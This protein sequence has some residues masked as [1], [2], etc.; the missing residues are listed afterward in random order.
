MTAE[1]MRVEAARLKKEVCICV[2]ACV[3]VCVCVRACVCIA[4]RCIVDKEV[5]YTSDPPQWLSFPPRHA[6]LSFGASHSRLIGLRSR[7][8][9]SNKSCNSWKTW[10]KHRS[11][12]LSTSMVQKHAL[13]ELSHFERYMQH[14]HALW[15]EI[16]N[17]TFLIQGPW[18][19]FILTA[20]GARRR[21]T[22]VGDVDRG[23]SY[24]YSTFSHWCSKKK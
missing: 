19:N 16:W 1:E 8:N 15:P 18:R 10:V 23:Q 9:F 14:F 12:I 11:T 4:I 22:R 21:Q 5:T 24:L 13:D 3:C 20:E 17:V 7:I 2:R 6:H